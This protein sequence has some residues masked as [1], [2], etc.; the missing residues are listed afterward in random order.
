MID[1][2]IQVVELSLANAVHVAF[3]V[4]AEVLVAAR[5]F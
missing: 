5:R 1:E 2:L 3:D 4:D